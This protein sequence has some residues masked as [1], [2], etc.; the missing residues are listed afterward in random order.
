MVLFLIPLLSLPLPGPSSDTEIFYF[1]LTFNLLICVY[2]WVPTCVY[3]TTCAWC[4]W[5]RD[6]DIRVP[7]LELKKFVSLPMWML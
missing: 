6:E 2:E 4:P 5:R 1:G 7:D 3:V